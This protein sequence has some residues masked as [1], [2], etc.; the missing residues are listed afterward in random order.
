MLLLLRKVFFMPLYFNQTTFD[1]KKKI[2][3]LI[4]A[5]FKYSAFPVAALFLTHE[6]V[7]IYTYDALKGLLS[8]EYKIVGGQFEKCDNNE[9]VE[10]RT[11]MVEGLCE[12]PLLCLIDNN[13]LEYSTIAV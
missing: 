3:K 5:D 2:S 10:V 13:G 7:I 1:M 6:E 4:R 11:E 8:P 9:P 12:K